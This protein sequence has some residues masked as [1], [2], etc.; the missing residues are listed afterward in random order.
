M[1]NSYTRE[2]KVAIIVDITKKLHTFPSKQGGTMNLMNQNYLFVSEFKRITR[3]WIN[4][5]NQEIG[6][7]SKSRKNT[8]VGDNLDV[9]GPHKT[10]IYLAFRVTTSRRLILGFGLGCWS[11]KC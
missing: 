11:C 1:S 7:Q 6:I 9:S 2:E 3:E 10:R 4:N 5:Q 8:T